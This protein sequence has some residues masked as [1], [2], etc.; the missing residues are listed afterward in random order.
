MKLYALFVILC[1]TGIQAKSQDLADIKKLILLK[2]YEKARPKIESYVSNSK[3][4]SDPEGIYYKA[5]VYAGLSRAITKSLAEC[6]GH[7]ETAYSTIQQYALMDTKMPLSVQ[8][9]H[10]TF[11]EIYYKMNDLAVRNYNEKNFPESYQLFTRALQ[12]HDYI[13]DRSLT[14]PDGLRL[15]AHD[16]DVVWNLAVLAKQLNQK[17]EMLNWYAKIADAGMNDAKYISMYDELLQHYRREKNREL[18]A[19]YMASAK[20]NFPA[21]LGYWEAKEMDFATEGLQNEALFMKYDELAKAMPD[22]YTVFYNYAIA[23]DKYLLTDAG[24]AKNANPYRAKIE[25]LYKKSLEVKSVLENNL[26]LANIYY[27]KL[28]D[29]QARMAKIKGTHPAEIKAKNELAAESKEYTEACTGYAE[30]A[31]K[32]LAALPQYTHIDKSNYKQILEILIYCYKASNN[33]AKV[34]EMELKKAEVEKL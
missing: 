9:N 26:Q 10:T 13:Y 3:N 34:A 15:T 7:C 19:R 11:F 5:K 1:C 30:A 17:N 2:Q 21:D 6:K 24:R 8:D 20:K 18:F 29:K 16:T 28:L 12:V 23:I 4:S 31:M 27:G 22:N 14:G 25:E 32:F 33:T